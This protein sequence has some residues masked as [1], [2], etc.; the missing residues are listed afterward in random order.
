MASLEPPRD[1]T[2]PEPGSRTARTILSRALGRLPGDLLAL[3]ETLPLS[4][5]GRDDLL[6]LKT[7]VR[8]LGA[9]SAGPR[10]AA[11][12]LHALR[13]PTVAALLRSIR[14]EVKK[15]SFSA[16]EVDP[17]LVELL[18][19]LAFELALAGV[20]E[21]P[22]TL[23]RA[24]PRLL[25]LEARADLRLP[26]DARALVFSS[27]EMRIERAAGGSLSVDLSALARGESITGLEV[28]RPYHPLVADMLFAV[29]D[30]NPRASYGAEPG[31]PGNPIDLGDHPA[32]EWVESL[33]RAI[34]PIEQHT[35]DLYGE[36]CLYVRQF[37]PAGYHAV[38]HR[39][40]SYRESV[41][42]IYMTL[43]PSPM[44][45]TEA[46]I[47]EFSHNKL[48]AL[49]ELDP[50]IKN[51]PQARY[52]SPVR[53]DLRPLRGVLLAVHAF[54]PV[55]H[56]YEKMIEGQHPLTRSP[57]FRERFAQIRGINREG[58][59]VVFAHAQPTAVGQAVIDEIK[60][61]I[62]HFGT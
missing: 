44:T 17:V 32:D 15:P 27:G 61:W 8:R 7:E 25:S 24:P 50:V 40:A 52:R 3:P 55:A 39:S 48:H 6:A 9:G 12:L 4:T 58:A 31:E 34:A 13:S 54:L 2:I 22:L 46:I 62:D 36:L 5:E 60:R 10:G 19:V 43:H 59:D 11:A 20:L 51:P 18:A 29:A 53:P 49:F 33:R 57:Y 38:T 37:L 21:R 47:H 30:D 16:A 45:L 35:P 42:A 26:A 14:N 41:G 1:I 23:H 28:S 56:L